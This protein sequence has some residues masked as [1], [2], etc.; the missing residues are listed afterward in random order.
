M[1]F[2]E[3]R[4]VPAGRFSSAARV[5][6]LLFSLAAVTFASSTTS[7]GPLYRAPAR[8]TTTREANAFFLQSDSQAEASTASTATT[9]Q[10]AD[11]DSGSASGVSA[12]PKLGEWLVL[13]PVDRRGRRPVQPDAVWAR[14]GM[15][16][17]V[18]GPT[19]GEELVGELGEPQRWRVTKP[20][21]DGWIRPAEGTTLGVAH[22][23]IESAETRVVLARLKSATTM[24]VGTR[25]YAGDVYDYGFRG[26]PIHLDRGTN[27]VFVNGIRGAFSL[28]LEEPEADVLFGTWDLTKP[29][30]LTDQLTVWMLGMPFVNTTLAPLE[31]TLW[32]GDLESQHVERQ[33]AGTWTLPAAQSTQVSFGIAP[34]GNFP[35]RFV[36]LEELQVPLTLESADGR[37][38]AETSVTLDCRSHREPHVRTVLSRIDGSV[39]KLAVV[40]HTD[41][42][43]ANPGMIV[44][45][46]GA[47]VEAERHAACFEPQPDL[48][49]VAPT[50]R[51]PYGF[52]WQDWGRLNLYETIFPM[53]AALRVDQGRIY[54]TGHS[55]GGH[56]TW[57]V[58]GI[59]SDLFAAIAPSAGWRGFD[60]YGGRPEGARS[61]L[62][63]SADRASEIES[64]LPNLSDVPAFILHGEA[65]ETVPVA[66]ALAMAEHYRAWKEARGTDFELHIEP[67]AGHW[68]DGEA[69]G[70]ECVA[71]PDMLAFLRRHERDLKPAHVR[72]TTPHPSVEAVHDWF[73][74]DQAERYGETSRV[75]ATYDAESELV[76]FDLENVRRFTV[77]LPAARAEVYAFRDGTVLAAPSDTRSKTFVRGPTGAFELSPIDDLR[78][79]RHD[80]GGP[81]KFGWTRKFVAVLPT[82][83][84]AEENEAARK[85]FLYDAT[86][87]AYR[88]NGTLYSMTD[89]ELL[90]AFERNV[91][92]YNN[93]VIYGNVQTNRAWQQVVPPGPF[94]VQRGRVEIAGEVHM[95]DD[96]AIVFVHRRHD[97]EGGI[98]LVN[99]S[100]GSLGD[101]L[102]PAIQHF[103]SGAGFPDYVLMSSAILTEGDGGVLDAGWLDSSWMPQR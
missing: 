87:W 76:S 88:G 19:E 58:A 8:A 70:V 15:G 92:R 25:A 74:I 67:G 42:S 77:M 46:H 75:D 50:N 20:E 59:D 2:L 86:V 4:S 14:H 98:V 6:S 99:G 43:V 39:Q 32:V 100:T 54:L 55:M 52:D 26:F 62:W 103:V 94:K 13:P 48:V 102:A 60:D 24:T 64:L 29:D 17:L 12:L 69:P 79:K 34:T 89:K 90:A 53:M 72:F 35:E 1:S 57:H 80:R 3:Q 65:D 44:A 23:T 61:E 49:V 28:T 82:S 71:H 16:P 63:R 73:R 93:L 51:R 11:P 10:D 5:L 84:R 97:S 68:W 56:G 21:A 81:I 85:R 47:G 38:L 18:T 30:A 31:V 101:R 9:E 27:H 7:A 40:P 78:E 83:G 66:E 95:G 41:E 45:L 37:I 33:F 22:T 91:H 96:L 36:D